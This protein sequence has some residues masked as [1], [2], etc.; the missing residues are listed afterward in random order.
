MK[1]KINAIFICLSYLGKAKKKSD[2]TSL[3]F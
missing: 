1:K 3:T 2:F